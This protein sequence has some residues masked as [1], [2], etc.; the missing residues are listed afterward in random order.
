MVDHTFIYTGAVR[1]MKSLVDAGEIGDLLY[2]DSVRISL[3]LVQSDI[4]VVWDLAP[5]DFSIMDYLCSQD[6]LLSPR[7]ERSISGT[8]LKTSLT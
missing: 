2:F 7:R 5:H 1:H 8:R 3:G 6:P 4:N